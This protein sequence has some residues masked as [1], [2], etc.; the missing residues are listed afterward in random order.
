MRLKTLM[1]YLIPAEKA[2]E[3]IAETK[4]RLADLDSKFTKPIKIVEL[5]DAEAI[6]SKL[7]NQVIFIR[8]SNGN[9]KI[10]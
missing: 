5:A 9:W 7:K 6:I 1:R 2:N 4:K 10:Y 8:H 3:K